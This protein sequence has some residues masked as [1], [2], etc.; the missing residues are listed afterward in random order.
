V[1]IVSSRFVVGDV[2]IDLASGSG[3]GIGLWAYFSGLER[4]S[5]AIVAR[6]VRRCVYRDELR[7]RQIAGIS[8][9]LLGV[10]G[11]STA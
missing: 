1:V 10:I 8:I 2:L 7:P 6:V 3:I 4:S 9:V 5:S 11:V